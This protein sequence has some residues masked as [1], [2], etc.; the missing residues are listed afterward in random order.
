MLELFQ[1]R[2]YVIPYAHSVEGFM[3]AGDDWFIL[4]KATSYQAKGQAILGTLA[5]C[6][7]HL[8]YSV[9]SERLP[10]SELPY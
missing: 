7:K 5:R 4:D 6:G 10:A 1:G 2:W 8:P 3:T 9:Y